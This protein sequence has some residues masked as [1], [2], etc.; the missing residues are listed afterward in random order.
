MVS[1]EALIPLD[2]NEGPDLPL[3]RGNYQFGGDVTHQSAF[4]S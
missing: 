1:P 3:G 4:K 2:G